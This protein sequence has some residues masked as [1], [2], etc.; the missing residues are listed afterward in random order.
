MWL[1]SSSSS[2]SGFAEA[3]D[4]ARERLTAPVRVERAWPAVL[5]AAFFAVA[6]LGFA[7]AAILAPPVKL[8]PAS[9][10]SVR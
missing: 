4:R 6:A 7:T 1:E 9:K 8:S 3:M 2:E 10:T 5:A